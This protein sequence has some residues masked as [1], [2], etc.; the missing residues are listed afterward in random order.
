[1]GA[2]RVQEGDRS[3]H[4]LFIAAA[5]RACECHYSTLSYRVAF[6]C[7]ILAKRETAKPPVLP[8]ALVVNRKTSEVAFH[9]FREVLFLEIVFHFQAV[10]F[11]RGT[12]LHKVR[13]CSLS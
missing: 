2:Y 7:P 11:C 13:L 9:P 5:P 4:R 10:I 12:P 8:E 6:L 1:M 3:Q